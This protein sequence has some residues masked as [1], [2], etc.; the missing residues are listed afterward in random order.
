MIKVLIVS[1]GK[2]SGGVESYTLILGKML[3]DKGMEV[4]Y[5]IRRGAW[6]EQKL[7]NVNKIVVNLDSD[8]LVDMRRLRHYVEEHKINIIH[9]NSN[10][11][12]F[13]SQL[14]KENSNCK[15]IGVIHGDVRIDQKHKGKV[16]SYVY[17]K[18]ETWLVNNKCT[19]CIA[20]SKSIKD[21]LIK[22]G[23]KENKID[24]IYT[25]IEPVAYDCFPDYFDH[26]L[27]ICTIGN[28]LSVKN[29][30]KLLEALDILKKEHSEIKINCDIYGEGKEKEFLEAYIIN[31][32]LNNVTLKGYDDKVRMK[33][34]RYQ[35]YIHP[36]KYES[37]GIAILEAMNAGCCIIANAVGGI[38]EIVKEDTGYLVDCN[39]VKQLAEQ[40]YSCYYNRDEIKVKAIAGKKMCENQF[41]TIH[42]LS[43]IAK[44]YGR[45]M[46]EVMCE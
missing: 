7:S 34:N 39:N 33:L 9:C 2:L 32:D 11:G 28:L 8:L 15:K 16:F 41:N 14:I 44:L 6:L 30:I 20:V 23:I 26:Q 13:I 19:Q 42:M 12:L 25:G 18:I 1:V 24:I 46:G 29:Q 36:S 21:I 4:H 35:L 3:A 37:F 10:N 22:R 5:A 40:I 43:Q 31:H 27:N 45:V 17:E 38:L